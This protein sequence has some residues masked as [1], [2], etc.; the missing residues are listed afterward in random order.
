L[1]TRRHQGKD[2]ASMVYSGVEIIDYFRKV[3]N[4]FLVGLMDMKAYP[5]PLYFTLRK[6]TNAPAGI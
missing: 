2:T 6:N 3:N 1:E 4:N 5:K